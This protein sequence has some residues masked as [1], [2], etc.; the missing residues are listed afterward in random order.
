MVA[1]VLS[2]WEMT[3]W[4][5]FKRKSREIPVS[6]PRI[7]KRRCCWGREQSEWEDKPTS[8]LNQS[9]LTAVSKRLKVDENKSKTITKKTKAA[10]TVEIPKKKLDPDG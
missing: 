1:R 5:V 10:V 6:L 9:D 2:S 8:S 4:H 7:P 3:R